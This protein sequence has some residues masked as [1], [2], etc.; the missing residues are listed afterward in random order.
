M[1]KRRVSKKNGG[2]EDLECLRFLTEC[3]ICIDDIDLNDKRQKIS[4]NKP[5][6]ISYPENPAMLTGLKVM[7]TAEVKYGTLE[8]QDVFLRCDYRVLKNDNTDVLSIVQDS[9]RP[10][11]LELQDFLLSL[12]HRYMDKGLTCAVE[13][14]G[15]H[16]YIKYCYK[17]KDL[18]GTNASLNREWYINVKPQKTSEYTDLIKT[19]PQSLQELIDKGYGC[20]RKR[21]IG[22]CDGGCHG[23][24]IPLAD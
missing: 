2:H 3:G 4:N 17:R 24:S 15:F 18:W 16:I 10:L 14:K 9:I 20:G 11:P 6:I 21:E 8:N 5:I 7:A 23:L 1:A 19:F 12:H 13:V 22:R